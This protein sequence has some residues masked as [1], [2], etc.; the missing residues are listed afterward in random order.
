MDRRHRLGF[1]FSYNEEWIA[2]TYYILNIIHA[3]ARLPQSQQP[4]VVIISNSKKDFQVVKKETGYSFLEFF[5][6]PVKKP[7]YSKLERGINKLG[8]FVG[9]A[10]I[11]KKRLP[12][13]EV[14][15]IYPFEYKELSRE[16]FPKV[17]WIPDFQ[18]V[19]LPELFSNELKEKRK[20]ERQNICQGDWVVFSSKDSQSDFNQLYPNTDIK[21]FVLP[22]AVTHPKFNTEDITDLRRKYNLPEHYFFAPNQFW[23]H[24]NHMVVLKA[25]NT[26]KNRGTL[27]HVAF[28]GKEDDHRNRSY[29]N[30]LKQFTIENDLTDLVHFLGFIPR[31]EQLCIFNNAI[32][33]IQPSKFE[34]WSTVVEDAKALNKFLI[35]SDLRVHREQVVENV[36]FFN[37]RRC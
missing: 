6:I 16:R 22:F 33:I 18:E 3:L 31:K 23:A 19:Y 26:L 10:K 34:G 2:G 21:Q 11:V 15:F 4:F 14:D 13:L 1:I 37:P 5:E 36:G 8:R 20:K 32:A 24:K 27:V 25:I 30:K 7:K 12:R 28:S 35:L 29:F 17:N 9:F